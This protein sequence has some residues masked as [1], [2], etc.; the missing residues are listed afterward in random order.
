MWYLFSRLTASRARV[1]GPGRYRAARGLWL[2]KAEDGSAVWEL[3]LNVRGVRLDKQIGAYPELTV[4]AARK[5]AAGWPGLARS[6]LDPSAEQERVRNAA[7]RNL[8][9]FYC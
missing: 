2:C 9:Q 7:A 8:D 5:E 4:K 6:G 3:C 1:A